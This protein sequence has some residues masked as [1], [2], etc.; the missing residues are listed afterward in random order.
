MEKGQAMSIDEAIA[1]ERQQAEEQ[2]DHIGTFDDEYSK[3]CEVWAE[4]HEQIANWLEE[5]K[6]INEMDLSIPQHFT[7]EQSDW[8]K[9]YCINRKTVCLESDTEGQVLA[10]VD[11]EDVLKQCKEN[12]ISKEAFE[13]MKSKAHRHGYRQGYSKAIDD[14]EEEAIKIVY[15]SNDRDR[16]PQ[17]RDMVADI[18]YKLMD[19]AKLLKEQNK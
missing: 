18:H 14:F 15:D 6:V 2:R 11:I 4:E 1:R 19:L 3:K 10:S 9:K 13:K 7:K 5:L 16:N 17:P 8:I 12:S